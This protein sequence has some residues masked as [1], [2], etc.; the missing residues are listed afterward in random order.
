MGILKNIAKDKLLISILLGGF[1]LRIFLTYIPGFKVDVDAWFYWAIRLTQVGLHN[2]YTPDIW[3]NYTPGYLYVLFFLGAIKSLFALDTNQFYFLLKLPA[4][5]V[6]IF[7][8]AFIYL[9]IKNISDKFTARI[10]AAYIAFNPALIFNST[11]WGQIDSILTLFMILSVYFLSKKKYILASIFL[12]LSFLI[13]PQAISIFPVFGLFIIKNFNFKILIKLT[14]PCLLTIFVLSLPFFITN[15]FFG[16]INLFFQMV[17]DYPYTSLFAYNFWGIIGFWQND[18]QIAFNFSY[19]NW[20]Y[21]LF[22]I[23]WITLI[24]FYL[25]KN[26]TLFA[27]AT[28]ATLSFYFLPTRV[29]DRYLYPSLVLIIFAWAEYKNTLLFFAAYFL[30]FIHFLNL[31]YV[32]VYYNELFYKNQPNFIPPQPSIYLPFL[33]QSI[34]NNAKLLS[35]ISFLL[36][37]IISVVLLKSK[38][39]KKA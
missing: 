7:L 37:I 15:P 29:H 35:A 26:L 27:L 31:Y 11:I 28:L 13:K 30:S 39:V 20:G 5:F 3:T 24:Y 19:Q 9:Y 36:F 8:T 1:L 4:I 6:D 12:G 33:Y 34:E 2:F 14:L 25:R 10:A 32:Y 17:G 18:K 38:H 23:Y 22:I 16:I 21:L